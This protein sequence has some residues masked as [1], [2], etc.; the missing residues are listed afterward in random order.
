M[1]KHSKHVLVSAD[2]MFAAWIFA[3]WML[4]FRDL[5]E[6]A[7][8]EHVDSGVALDHVLK[9]LDHWM[10][11][12]GILGNMFGSTFEPIAMDPVVFR[13]PEAR[14]LYPILIWDTR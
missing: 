7:L 1:I 4:A 9:L 13:E 3:V 10:K 2:G 5:V 11:C 14:S 12:F 6:H 8:N